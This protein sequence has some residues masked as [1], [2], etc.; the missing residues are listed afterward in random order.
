MTGRLQVFTDDWGS[1]LY[2][3]GGNAN[4]SPQ[5]AVGSIYA[6]DIYIR[7]IGK[8]AS[9]LNTGTVS[10]GCNFGAGWG[11]ATNCG[12]SQSI[13]CAA[14]HVPLIFTYHD[15]FGL[16]QWN[17]AGTWASGICYRA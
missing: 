3:A 16:G 14:G 9:Q 1:L 6:N 13:D 17:S 10:G 15:A 12:Q 4:A 8:W 11:T 5:S 2:G 7:S